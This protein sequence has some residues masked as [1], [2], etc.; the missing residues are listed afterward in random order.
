MFY[1]DSSGNRYKLGKP[2]YYNNSSYTVTGATHENFIAL[3]FTQVTPDT[4]PDSRFYSVTGPDING[5]YTSTPFDLA[6]L[7]AKFIKIEKESS[8]QRLR[9]T[10]WYVL[11][12][13]D[14]AGA[15]PTAITTFRAAVRTAAETRCNQI[16]ACSTVA[17]LEEKIKEPDQLYDS[18]TETFSVNPDR[19]EPWPT[20][21][22]DVYHLY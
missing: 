11:R 6:D 15:V 16:N 9:S 13:I 21:D 3:G 8:Y 5:E 7:K 4:R 22:E 18:A 12:N 14:G 10:D 1:K 19:M 20:I 17:E 2:F